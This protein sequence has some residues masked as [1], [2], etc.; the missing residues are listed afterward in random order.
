MD[1]STDS[2][3]NPNNGIAQLKKFFSEIS[4]DLTNV[5]A[6][7]EQVIRGLL[8]ALVRELVPTLLLYLVLTIGVLGVLGIGWL[9]LAQL[10]NPALDFGLV[11]F[12]YFL[13]LM[14]IASVWIG[15]RKRK[16][17]RSDL[18]KTETGSISAISTQT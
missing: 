16:S 11:M 6:E 3:K 17:K 12:F 7:G 8:S 4:S 2:Q 13:V 1:S 18:K 9:K 15:L 14:A 5:K 10:F